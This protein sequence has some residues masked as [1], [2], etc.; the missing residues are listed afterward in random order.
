MKYTVVW[1]PAAEQEL[2][3]LWNAATD[4]NALTAAAHQIDQILKVKPE[5]AGESRPAGTRILVV[6]P[7]VVRYKVELGDCLVSVAAIWR[8]KK[9]RQQP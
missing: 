9:R 2:A 7:L 3:A 5:E 4:R 8:L 1:K 6:P